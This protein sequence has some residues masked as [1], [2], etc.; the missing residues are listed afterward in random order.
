V[1]WHPEWDFRNNPLSVIIL[2]TFG[3][4]ARAYQTEERK[5]FFEKKNQKTFESL[6]PRRS[7]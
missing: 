1:Q 5:F 4:A 7:D 3:Q 6:E 2:R